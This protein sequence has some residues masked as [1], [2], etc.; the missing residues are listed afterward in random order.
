RPFGAISPQARESRS[1]SSAARQRLP[2]LR[3]LARVGMD[4]FANDAQRDLLQITAQLGIKLPKF[5]PE[6]L[7][8]KPARCA[9]HH[10]RATLAIVTIGFDTVTAAQSQKQMP[11]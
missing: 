6:H 2:D 11:R 1:V 3:G 7:V 5:R 9:Q 4:A 10:G 8:D